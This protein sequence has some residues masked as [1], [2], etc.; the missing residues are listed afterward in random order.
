MDLDSFKSSMYLH[1]VLYSLFYH[2]GTVKDFFLNPTT[3]RDIFVSQRWATV[4]EKA[5]EWRLFNQ[6]KSLFNELSQCVR[7]VTLHEQKPHLIFTNN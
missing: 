4:H 5:A 1:F 6:T 3:A 7:L 2:F